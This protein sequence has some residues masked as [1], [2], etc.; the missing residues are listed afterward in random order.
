MSDLIHSGIP[1]RGPQAR[2]PEWLRVKVQG[3]TSFNEVGELVEGLKL[4]TVCESARCPNIWECWGS[5]RTATFMILGDVC[6]RNCRYC[7]VTKGTPAP[8]DPKEP[9]H[10]ASAVHHLKLQ[11]A[12]ITS[13]DRDDL[14]DGGAAQ[15]AETISA[16]RTS[17]PKTRIEVLVPD[18]LGDGGALQVVLEAR[19]DVLNHNTETVPR[20]FPSLRSKGDFAR[21]VEVLAGAHRYRVEQG[22][23]LVTKSGLMV[24][25][26]ETKAEILAAMDELREAH[27]DVLTLGQYLNPT[28]DHAPI[29][30]FY[31][32]EEFADLKVEGLKRGFTHV[33]SGPLVRSSY[34]AAS[35]VP[36]SA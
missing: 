26:G 35:H 31:T 21:S 36:F 29:A 14:P 20:L 6:T 22:V 24:G 28:A 25:L 34:H 33:E 4:H 18:F 2:R 23:P 19:P 32:L 13:V 1:K 10:V 12:V 11:H 15:F 5:Q 16:V 27:C 8:V 9:E 17:N 30:R 7:A 3:S